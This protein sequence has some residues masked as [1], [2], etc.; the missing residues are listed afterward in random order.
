[1]TEK[2]CMK[3]NPSQENKEPKSGSVLS[4]FLQRD[5]LVRLVTAAGIVGIALLFLS[6]RFS[7]SDNA[8]HRE[9]QPDPTA[10]YV[11]AEEYRLALC[12]ELGYM[13]AGIEGAG[14]TKVMLTIDGTIRN[15]Y[16][17]DRDLQTRENKREG[18][19]SGNQELQ[20]NEKTTCIVVRSKDGTEQPLTVGQQLPK[21]R[22]VLIVCEGGD[23][24]DVAARI[25]TA[26]SAVLNLSSSHICVQKLSV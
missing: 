24:E 5:R 8:S 6:S 12:D 2:G 26:V 19:A 3:T 21:V 4:G 23:R 9:E 25:K 1:M 15:I 20:N 18:E 7:G 11:T 13:I 14:R 10:G 17:T 16:A 22:G